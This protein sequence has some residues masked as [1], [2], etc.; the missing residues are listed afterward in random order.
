MESWPYLAATCPQ[1][2][3]YFRRLVPLHSTTCKL[4]CTLIPIVP[5]HNTVTRS[6]HIQTHIKLTHARI[7]NASWSGWRRM[8]CFLLLSNLFCPLIDWRTEDWKRAVYF[9]TVWVAL[10]ELQCFPSFPFV[11]I[12][13]LWFSSLV[14]LFLDEETWLKFFCFKIYSLQCKVQKNKEIWIKTILTFFKIYAVSFAYAS[15]GF[16]RGLA[17][18]I[19]DLC[20]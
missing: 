15:N 7:I 18:S 12:T 16:V 17:I 11:T 6:Y 2:F 9:I 14:F 4:S 13:H 5:F 10:I 3:G 1:T 20:E 8:K 19:R